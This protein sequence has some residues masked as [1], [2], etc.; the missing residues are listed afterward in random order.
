MGKIN[1]FANIYDTEGNLIR[2]VGDDGKLKNYTVEELEALVDKLAEEK[3]ENGLV[4]DPR[5]LNNVSSILF[6]EYQKHGISKSLKNKL[7]ELQEQRASGETTMV[8]KTS[9]EAYKEAIEQAMDD[10]KEPELDKEQLVERETNYEPDTY[11]QFEELP[12]SNELS[13]DFEMIKEAA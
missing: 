11:V 4:K 2:H 5:A 6:Q 7:K 13:K 9:D 12:S 1:K 3:D 8:E 10:L